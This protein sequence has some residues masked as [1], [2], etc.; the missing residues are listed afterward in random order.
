MA[1][2]TLD[3][4][5]KTIC[6]GRYG[7]T[8]LLDDYCA[9]SHDAMV[10]ARND[11]VDA[12]VEQKLLEGMIGR[13]AAPTYTEIYGRYGHLNILSKLSESERAE[14]L[15][16]HRRI[17][18]FARD[19]IRDVEYYL[20]LLQLF[21]QSIITFGFVS[22]EYPPVARF[23]AVARSISNLSHAITRCFKLSRDLL[24]PASHSDIDKLLD[25]KTKLWQ[26]AKLSFE[27]DL[28][29]SLTLLQTR[30]FA[31]GGYRKYD[32]RFDE[33]EMHRLLVEMDAL[34]AAKKQHLELVKTWRNRSEWISLKHQN[35]EMSAKAE[36]R[37]LVYERSA[38]LIDSCLEITVQTVDL[39]KTS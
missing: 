35:A 6:H 7:V 32:V 25:A 33:K 31:Q 20:R 12:L 3:P 13:Q 38:K 21:K 16:I 24:E 39:F 18:D 26:E 36:S 11:V 1:C 14:L 23:I 22:D 28:L 29:D 5:L 27:T 37:Q 2:L 30:M 34:E 17:V 15:R 19:G 9:L 10:A 4:L 8:W